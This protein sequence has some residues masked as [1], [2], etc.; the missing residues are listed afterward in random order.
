MTPYRAVICDL[1]GTLVDNFNAGEYAAIQK[2]LASILGVPTRNFNRLWR[3]SFDDRATGVHRDQR[4]SFR[5]ICREVGVPVTEAQLD[6][7]FRV[8][9]D[10]AART[11][12][13]RADTLAALDALRSRGYL[14]ALVSDCTGEVPHLWPETAF[15]ERFDAAVFSCRVG[16]KKPDPCIYRRAV[17]E[18]RIE[19]EECL[20]VGDGSSSELTGAASLGM[21]AVLIRDP[22]DADSVYLEREDD[23]P[24]ERITYLSELLD[25]LP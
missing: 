1:F 3:D 4:D 19:P 24:G 8:R 23:W 20:Y 21:R 12:R 11:L 17:E 10:Y 13:P 7:A 6:E 2:Q 25:L 22:S 14:T 15:E 18:L 9:L 5:Y 16:A